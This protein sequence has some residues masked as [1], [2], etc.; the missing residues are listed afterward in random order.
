M[1]RVWVPL[2][3]GLVGTCI[4]I[5]LG[6]WQIQR[7]AEKE[8]YLARIDARIA[9]APVALS[10]VPD[11]ARDQYLPVEVEGRFEPAT[12]HVLVGVKDLGAGYRLIQ[13]F[14]TDGRRILVDRGFIALEAKDAPRSADAV[15]LKGNLH[16]PDEIS[17]STPKPDLTREIWFARDVPAMAKA[18]GTEPVMVIVR[19]QTPETDAG[20]TPLPVDSSTIPNDHLQYVVTWFSLAAIWVIMTGYF[21]W[22]SK[23]TTTGEA[24]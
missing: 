3:F 14:E 18:L 11:A 9:E 19:S 21:L 13:P 2:M 8:A 20:I 15:M 7:L 17:S 12:V 16:W 23:R 4:L 1:K 10:E 6:V 5:G 22:R 24:V